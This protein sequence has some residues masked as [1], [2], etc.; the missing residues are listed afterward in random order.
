[1]NVDAVVF[2]SVE[3]NERGGGVWRAVAVWRDGTVPYEAP[4]DESDEIRRIAPALADDVAARRPLEAPPDGA[5]E[6]PAEEMRK[7]AMAENGSGSVRAP[8]LSG[9]TV[10]PTA[11]PI[12]STP[13][14]WSSAA[15]NPVTRWKRVP[16]RSA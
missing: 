9:R 8:D 15:S 16:A 14:N 2:G 4:F 10:T 3:L 6:K 7:G 1:M 11:P 13:S 5:S 12:S